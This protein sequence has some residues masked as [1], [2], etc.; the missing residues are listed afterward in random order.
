MMYI[1]ILV[2]ISR[3][4]DTCQPIGGNRSNLICVYTM[5]ICHIALRLYISKVFGGVRLKPSHSTINCI[6]CMYML[7]V[8]PCI[9]L[10]IVFSTIYLFLTLFHNNPM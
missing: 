8:H 6:L 7:F 10:V 3:S 4:I 5:F 9:L 1:Y 2:K